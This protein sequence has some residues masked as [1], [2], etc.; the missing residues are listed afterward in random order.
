MLSLTLTIRQGDRPNQAGAGTTVARMPQHDERRP[1]GHG[2]TWD[3]EVEGLVARPVGPGLGYSIP[4]VASTMA[5]PWLLEILYVQQG[6]E[7]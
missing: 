2:P 7:T 5:D 1:G 6:A 4:P 3:P